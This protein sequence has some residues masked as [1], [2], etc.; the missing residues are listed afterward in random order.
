MTKQNKKKR[1]ERKTT[2]TTTL[3]VTPLKAMMSLRKEYIKHS[4]RNA[5]RARHSV[6][7]VSVFKSKRK[8]ITLSLEC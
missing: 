5:F 4:L 7:L 1:K 8:E 6:Q 3:Y 2:T